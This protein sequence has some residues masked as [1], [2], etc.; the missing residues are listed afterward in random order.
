MRAVRI[1]KDII[2][3]IVSIPKGL[4]VTL[5]NWSIARPSVTEQYPE[6]KPKLPENYRGM[7]TLPVDPSTGESPCIACGACERICPEGI[8]KVEVDKS[9]PK[10]R[11]PAKFEIDISRCMWCGLCMEAC[12]KNC[13]RPA[14]KFEFACY[15]REGMIYNLEDLKKLGG[16]LPVQQE[17]AASDSNEQSAQ[18]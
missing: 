4:W 1:I 3:F 12:P 18:S 10:N 17:E 6:E 11:K 14:R 2:G 16:E 5:V 9:D 8:I 15:S 13:L 7:P